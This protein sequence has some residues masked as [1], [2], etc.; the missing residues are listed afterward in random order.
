VLNR[1]TAGQVNKRF[2]N[3]L[4]DNSD[5]PFFAFLNY[6]DAH[7]PYLPPPAY[8]QKFGATQH[9]VK[10]NHTPVDAGRPER[11]KLPPEE[12]R[13][14]QLLY[15]AAVA[16]IDDQLGLLLDELENRG[17]LANTMVMVVADHGEHF[18]EHR[19]FGHGNSLYRSSIEVPL[20]VYFPKQ[21]PSG[22]RIPSPVSVR[23]LPTTILDL[24]GLDNRLSFPGSSLARYWE[25]TD[26]VPEF[27]DEIILSEA[28]RRSF[29]PSWIPLGQGNMKSL[30]SSRYQYIWNSA[31]REELYDYANDESETEDL[32][33]SEKGMEMLGEF[34]K[35]LSVVGGSLSEPAVAP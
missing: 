16:Y 22:R 21:V 7:E 18:G 35:T 8:A 32:S 3:W 11:W 4:S 23:N 17:L 27:D 14:E 12:V 9:R 34:K 13:N 25:S 5:R 20:V 10:L 15:E 28:K 24:A 29:R 19:L 1:L 31:G 30:I 6:M 26:E 33:K 2:L